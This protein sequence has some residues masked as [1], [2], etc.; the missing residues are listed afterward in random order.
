MNYM[1]LIKELAGL[2]PG[3]DRDQI[4]ELA[5]LEALLQIAETL[6]SLNKNG[7]AIQDGI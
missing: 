5:K 6:D 1:K 7:I 4:V 2:H 3:L